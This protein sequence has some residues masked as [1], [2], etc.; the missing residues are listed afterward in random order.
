MPLLVVEE[1]VGLERSQ[2][3]SLRDTAHEKRLIDVDAPGPKRIQHSQVSRE[4]A[5][6]HQGCSDGRLL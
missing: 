1:D 6:R 2:D 5:G 4:V 3:S